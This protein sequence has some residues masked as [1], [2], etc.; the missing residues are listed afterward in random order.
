[1]ENIELVIYV[2]LFVAAI[3]LVVKHW[4]TGRKK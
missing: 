3:Y 2:A 4:K 1:M